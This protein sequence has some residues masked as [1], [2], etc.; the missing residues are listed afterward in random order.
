[1]S[2]KVLARTERSVARS[3]RLSTLSGASCLLFSPLFLCLVY[4]LL[5]VFSSPSPSCSLLLSPPLLSFFSSFASFGSQ[6]FLALK[7][8]PINTHTYIHTHSHSH[9]HTDTHTQIYS[10]THTNHSSLSVVVVVVFGVSFYRDRSS[11]TRSNEERD[12]ER[13]RE[14]AKYLSSSTLASNQH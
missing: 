12:E 5:S 14:R 7:C 11:A 13:E 9:T 8:T 1:M 6:C 4:L 2:S 10:H 3:L